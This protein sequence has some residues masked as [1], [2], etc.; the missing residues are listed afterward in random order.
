[1]N[2]KRVEVD[3]DDDKPL[4][5]WVLASWHCYWSLSVNFVASAKGK[6]QADWHPTSDRMQ[7]YRWN[8]YHAAR[9][10][11]NTHPQLR[12]YVI[13]NL[14]LIERQAVE[15]REIHEEWINGKTKTPA[16]PSPRSRDPP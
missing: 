15:Q 14:E 3:D 11:Q 5:G 6:P 12:G 16:P 2:R 8:S 10:F 1:M 13:L 9:K 4:G 7:A